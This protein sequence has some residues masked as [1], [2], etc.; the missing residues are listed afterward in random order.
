MAMPA[1]NQLLFN[2]N[3]AM[4]SASVPTRFRPPQPIVINKFDSVSY[5]QLFVHF[6]RAT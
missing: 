2:L 3:P 4:P 5:V 1:D 6:S